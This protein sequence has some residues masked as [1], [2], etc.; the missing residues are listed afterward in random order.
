MNRVLIVDDDVQQQKTIEHAARLAGFTEKQIVIVGTEADAEL[1]IEK[2]FALA[3]VD[4]MLTPKREEEGIR[5][6]KSIKKQQPECLIIS[7]TTKA[8]RDSGVRALKAGACDF[9]RSDDDPEYV[10]WVALLQLRI[11]LWKAVIDD[12][13]LSQPA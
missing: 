2:P 8:K 10:N 12:R 3:V 6:V 13:S 11:A 9:I 4:I 1:A 5:L 7:L